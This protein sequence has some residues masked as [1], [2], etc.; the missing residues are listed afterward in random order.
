[1]TNIFRALLDNHGGGNLTYYLKKMSKPKLQINF[2]SY[3]FMKFT[4]SSKHLLSCF[5]FF[6]NA[7]FHH[8]TSEIQS[9]YKPPPNGGSS[10][11][12]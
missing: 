2:G 6:T 10:F 5:K 7:G 3:P 12:N 9:M 11:L 4:K 1:M 8:F